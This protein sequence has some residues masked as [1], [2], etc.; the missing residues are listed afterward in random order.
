M[1]KASPGG[2]V[3]LPRGG[4][5]SWASVPHSRHGMARQT[6]V[7]CHLFEQKAHVPVRLHIP[8]SSLL[9]RPCHPL[10]R[11]V[12]NLAPPLTSTSA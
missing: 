1:S 5:V 3:G 2:T 7:R 11:K 9:F 10:Q 12:M 8:R 4:W 6:R